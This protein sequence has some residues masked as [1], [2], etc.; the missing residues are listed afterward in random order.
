MLLCTCT[1]P[2]FLVDD[3]RGK[4]AARTTIRFEL[5]GFEGLPGG[6]PL[7]GFITWNSKRLFPRE[8]QGINIADIT[9]VEHNGKVRS[10]NDQGESR[11]PIGNEREKRL[12]FDVCSLFSS[13][14]PSLRALFCWFLQLLRPSDALLWLVF[15]V[16]G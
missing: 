16:F 13:T 6:T 7:G 3:Q 14:P 2:C 12:E 8:Q 9:K 11:P 1:L 4:W 10:R 15:G 5:N